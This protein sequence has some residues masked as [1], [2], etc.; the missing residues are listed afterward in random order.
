MIQMHLKV[1]FGQKMVC[2]DLDE[3]NAKMVKVGD[4]VFV[5]KAFSSYNETST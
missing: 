2:H 1:Y 3:G 5:I 4:F